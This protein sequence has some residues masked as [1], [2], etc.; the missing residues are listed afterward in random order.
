MTLRKKIVYFSLLN[1]KGQNN[2]REATEALSVGNTSEQHSAEPSHSGH[3]SMGTG[4]PPQ[5]TPRLTFNP[6]GSSAT[7]V[8]PGHDSSDRCSSSMASLVIFHTAWRRSWFVGPVYREVLPK[9]D[10]ASIMSWLWLQKEIRYLPNDGFVWTK[11]SFSLFLIYSW[12]TILDQNSL[13]ADSPSPQPPLSPFSV[14][15]WVCGVFF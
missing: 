8:S 15:L 5:D 7:A 3:L 1:R 2:A 10:I 6:A 11:N 4:T 14:C 12:H 9:G 13:P